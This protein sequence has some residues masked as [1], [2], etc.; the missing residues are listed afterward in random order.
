MCL[1]GR[2]PLVAFEV[3]LSGGCPDSSLLADLSIY[4]SRQTLFTEGVLLS[5]PIL[6]SPRAHSVFL[7]LF[8]LFGSS[9]RG[10]TLA[11]AA[12]TITIA[13]SFLNDHDDNNP[14][15]PNERPQRR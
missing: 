12:T 8:W 11:A 3:R 6:S 4:L 1:G 7:S 10:D 9:A 5:Y 14:Y 13:T 2:G 15:R